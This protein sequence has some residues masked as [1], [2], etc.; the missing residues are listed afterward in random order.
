MTNE[1]IRTLEL[2]GWKKFRAIKAEQPGGTVYQIAITGKELVKNAVVL[3]KGIDKDG[4]QRVCREIRLK[5]INRFYASND[6]LLPNNIIGSI[7]EGHFHYE[8]GYIWM[9]P[10]VVSEIIDGQHR[11][12]GFHKDYNETDINFDVFF[13]FIVDADTP[14]KAK[15]FYKINKEQKKINPSLAFDLLSLINDGGFD[16]DVSE[17]IKRLNDEPESPFHTLI[18][19]NE[20]D[21]GIIS[22]ANM[23]TVARDFLKTSIGRNFAREDK[24]AENQLYLIFRNY[25]SAVKTIFAKEWNQES[26][27]LKK[28]LGIGALSIV[29]TDVLNEHV[30][31]NGRNKL[32]QTQ[33]IIEILEPAS[34]FEFDDEDIKGLGGKKGQNILA[35]KI[36]EELEMGMFEEE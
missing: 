28:T 26:S 34:D 33:E 22:L 36:R 27:I 6:A 25:F 16:Q 24:I 12:W 13:A 15:L 32:P 19:M 21:N 9:N 7:K 14:Q 17:V 30:R 10:D 35:D 5:R 31:R 29:M 8:D 4:I 1:K 2:K 23:M 20:T 18:K 11:L 3:R